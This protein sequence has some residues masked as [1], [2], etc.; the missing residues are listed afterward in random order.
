MFA[1]LREGMRRYLE[2]VGEPQGNRYRA[3]ALQRVILDAG[4]REALFPDPD[5]LY[6]RFYAPLE[7]AIGMSER[8]ALAVALR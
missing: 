6:A 4:Y 7:T 2:H 8:L 1:G 3:E 5:D